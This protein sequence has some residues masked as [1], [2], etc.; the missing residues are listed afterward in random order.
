MN[1]TNFSRPR[2]TFIFSNG[3]AVLTDLPPFLFFF[4]QE[5]SVFYRAGL[6]DLIRN[7]EIR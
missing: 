7:A 2:Y 6:P 1:Q 5:K 3:R 4:V